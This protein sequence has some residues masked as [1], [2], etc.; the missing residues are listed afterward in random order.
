MS[1]DIPQPSQNSDSS[2]EQRFVAKHNPGDKRPVEELFWQ[3]I[4]NTADSVLLKSS[5]RGSV[6]KTDLAKSI[7][8]G[9]LKGDEAIVATALYNN[10]DNV[11]PAAGILSGF[12]IGKPQAITH[13]DISALSQKGITAE[14]QWHE[15][16]NLTAWADDHGGLERLS[17][18][19]SG[20]LSLSDINAAQK[21]AGLSVEDKAM[22]AELG[23]NF[24]SIAGSSSTIG[25]DQI[26]SYYDKSQSNPDFNLVDGFKRDM[27]SVE[28]TQLSLQSHKLFATPGNPLASINADSVREGFGGDC[29]FK[30]AL[31]GLAQ[32]RPQDIAGMIKPDGSNFDVSLPG[33]KEKTFTLPQPSDADLA[34][35][36]RSNPGG[37]WSTL[38]D[39]AFGQSVYNQADSQ[40]K[41]KMNAEAHGAWAGADGDQ[42]KAIEALTGHK[43]F[44]AHIQNLSDSD[45][46]KQLLTGQNDKR[47]MVLNTANASSNTSDGFSP[48]HAF[49]IT[50][51]SNVAGHVELTI[52]DPRDNGDNNP[53]QGTSKITL[54]DLK[55]NFSSVYVETNN[56]M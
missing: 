5:Q 12:G 30:A 53:R 14:K 25:K 42:E 45:L 26:D 7:E 10:F 48:G 23:A 20:K 29:A 54:A 28:K 39:N 18:G 56:P 43:V 9:A 51:V 49:T 15:V 2:Y 22:L 19:A 55:K 52:R 6:T 41:T 46:T 17:H 11:K 32:A 21:Q 4:M 33:T 36:S 24:K 8:S 16:D 31:A 37:F 44:K 34:L 50:N 1:A 47:V 13:E 27:Y 3:D 38:M 40:T 35:F